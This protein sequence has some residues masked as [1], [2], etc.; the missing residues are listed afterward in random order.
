[1]SLWRFGV[2]LVSPSTR[3]VL[4][5]SIDVE[6]MS[7]DWAYRAVDP[8]HSVEVADSTPRR[9]GSLRVKHVPGWNP[10]AVWYRPWVAEM[11]DGEWDRTVLGTF[12]C[13]RMPGLSRT[14]TSTTR[15]I[16]LSEVSGRFA[17]E[18]LT[19]PLEVGPE[20]MPAHWVIQDLQA[21]FGE[22]DVSQ[23]GLSQKRLGDNTGWSHDWLMWDVDTPVI[24]VYDELLSY[25]GYEP[26]RVDVLGRPVSH[27]ARDFAVEEATILL[28]GSGSGISPEVEVAA[29]TP[30]IPNVIVFQ[31]RGAP[32]L[33]EDGNGWRIV[34]N[35]QTGPASIQQRGR[36]VTATV[37]VDADSQAELDA[38]AR[39]RA[40]LMFAGGGWTMSAIVRFLPLDD[41]DVVE[42]EHT[43]GATGR[44]LTVAHG[45][46]AEAGQESA[47]VDMSWRGEL[48]SGVAFAAAAA[49][50][51]AVSTTGV[52]YRGVAA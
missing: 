11:V 46:S 3:D 5:Q 34:R 30:D 21:R 25:V 45:V 4:A 50:P 6:S 32:S 39:H 10:L 27:E 51:P 8:T 37:T 7:V 35:E 16:P 36:T 38:I 42:L 24:D 9:T 13:G 2:D 28:G 23:M 18:R 1:V 43:V 15:V 33:A 49:S 48:V 52:S 26:L 17:E 40:P 14:S 19:E 31:A 20:T 12:T 44:W 22:P 47:I 29:V 41:C